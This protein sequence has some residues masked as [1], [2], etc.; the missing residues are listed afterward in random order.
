MEERTIYNYQLS[1]CHRCAKVP[2]NDCNCT[3]HARQ[4]EAPKASH[5][6]EATNASISSSASP[7]A[8]SCKP[9]PPISTW[10]D[11]CL[12]TGQS[13]SEWPARSH[14]FKRRTHSE[15]VSDP[16]PM[17]FLQDKLFPR[18]QCCPQMAPQPLW[19][20]AGTMGA[21]W[22]GPQGIDR[23]CLARLG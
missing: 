14:L 16:R 8:K 22:K 3:A 9:L 1:K 4:R 15:S 6:Q 18:S 5:A 21:I 2:S 19:P 13:W 10:W 11:R 20:A 17:A 7:C 12:C 23:D